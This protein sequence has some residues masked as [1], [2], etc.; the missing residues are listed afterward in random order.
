VTSFF[1]HLIRKQ[2]KKDEK[3]NDPSVNSAQKIRMSI[4]NE[5]IEK[6]IA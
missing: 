3:Q 5:K 4:R 1:V 2:R 6:L